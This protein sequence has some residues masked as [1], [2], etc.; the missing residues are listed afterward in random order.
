MTFTAYLLK[1]LGSSEDGPPG[2]FPVQGPGQD[3][4]VGVQVVESRWSYGTAVTNGNNTQKT[5]AGLIHGVM[6][7]A[8]G[9]G[10]VTLYDNTAASGT[11]I[12]GAALTI[13]ASSAYFIPLDL[14]FVNGLTV[15]SSS[16]SLTVT[17]IYR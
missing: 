6:I 1:M 12:G 14:P 13:T 10:S 11:I 3:P 8:G 15:V 7:N 5:G 17:P 2:N 9:A 16:A 4:A